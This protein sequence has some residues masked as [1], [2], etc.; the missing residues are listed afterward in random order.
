MSTLISFKPADM[1]C[2]DFVCART[3]LNRTALL[4]K[5]LWA[6]ARGQ[7]EVPDLASMQGREY[8]GPTT[9]TPTTPL[10]QDP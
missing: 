4:R 3:G 2:I 5:L 7:I 10:P 6:Y 8:K 9:L 1:A